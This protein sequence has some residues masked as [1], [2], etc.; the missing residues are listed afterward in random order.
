MSRREPTRDE[1]E[2]M[3]YVDGELD[4]ARRSAFEERLNTE[5]SLAL[6]VAELERLAVLARQVTPPEPMD[7]E[8]RRLA[9]DPVQRAGLPLGFLASALGA[10]GL[11]L[12]GIVAILVDP[13]LELLPKI[14]LTLLL[15]G[16]LL[17]FLLVARARL[18]TLPF[19][20]YRDVQR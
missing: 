17:V 6:E 13:S 1:L 14:F 12:W 19:D 18:R 15:L 5:R 9:A 20:P 4:P 11:F 8:W 10:I 3:A 16:L 7:S 2:A